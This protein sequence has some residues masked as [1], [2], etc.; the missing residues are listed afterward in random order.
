M[1]NINIYKHDTLDQLATHAAIII[2]IYYSL[3]T[4]MKFL[5]PTIAAYLWFT[6]YE[7]NTYLLFT[8]HNMEYRIP[9]LMDNTEYSGANLDR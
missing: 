8:I 5:G 1:N 9:P 4:I 3:L 6:N 2:Q 7:Q